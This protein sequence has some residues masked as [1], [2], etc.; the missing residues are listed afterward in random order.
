MNRIATSIRNR[1][2]L[3]PPQEKSL[4]I[5]AELADK[6][7]L[8]KSVDLTAELEKVKS[9]YPTC[10]DF[11]RNFPSLCFALATGVGKTRL[12]GAFIAY[13]YLAKGIKNFFVLA[14]N[15]TIYSKLKTE[16]EETSHPK[17]VF[18]GIGEFVHQRPGIITG[19]NYEN[20]RQRGLF[21][22][23][24]HINI[25][26]ISKI[27]AETRGGSSPR[28]KRLAECLGDSYFS[29]LINLEDLV[30][31]MDESHHYRADRGMQVI[32]ELNP[33]LGLELTATPQVEK[34]AKPVKFKNVVYE[35]SLAKAMKDGFVKEPAVATRK[36]F[37]PD[38][39]KK[40]PED[41][42]RIKL[43]DGIRLHEDTKVALDIYARDNKVQTVK[44]F[45]LV[46]AKETNHAG[47]L[48]ELIV[49]KSFF[50]GY[51]ADKVME[52]HSNQQGGEKDENI[53]Q[54]LSLESS[55]N[56]I[57]IVIHVN[58]LKEGWDVANLYTIIPLRS[59][60]SQTLREQT[61]GRGLRLPY[62]K[63]TGSDKVDKLTI[64]AHDRFQEILDEANMPDSIIRLENIIQIDP[65]ELN[66]QKEVVTS[67]SSIEQKMQEEQKRI[68]SIAQPEEKEKAQ[69]GLEVKRAVFSTLPELNREVKSIN[70]L[71]KSEIKEIAIEKI[72]QAISKSP[73]QSLFAGQMIKEVEKVYD[74]LVDEFTRNIIEIPRITVQQSGE[75]RSGFNNFE[76]DVKN[77]NFQPVSEEI[78]VKKLREQENSTDIV[79]GK[80]RIVPDSLD[81]IIVN[82]IINYSEIDYDVQA[83]LIFKLAGQVIEKFKTYLNEEQ[84]MNVVQYHKNEIGQYVYAQMMEHFYC[85]AP[86]FLKPIVRPFT[87]IE[88]PNFS[89]YTKDSIHHYRETITPTNKIPSKVFSGF[90]KACHTLYKFDS[91]TEK[92][93]ACILEQDK[94]VLKW[95]RPAA[96]QF[97]IYWKHNSRQ[98]HPDFVA[99]TADAI[100][101]IETKKDGDIDSAE[102]QE[103]SQ[104]ALT[105]CVHATEFTSQNGGKPWKYILIPHDVVKLNMGFDTLTKHYEYKNKGSKLAAQV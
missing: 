89:K 44:P 73:Q 47:K 10:A 76:L 58:M 91:K 38:Q 69:I 70:E 93:F 67:V 35:Y 72:R 102:V 52:I 32:N 15:L 85:E 22:S 104:A 87:R 54:L 53:A 79:I 8:K 42:D 81:K 90:K 60:A 4:N 25:F 17:Y 99:E 7:T 5:L 26:N 24:I 71:T 57:E 39:Y 95:L 1:L 94:A 82:E 9:S 37:D 16:F 6:L 84:I 45:V 36:D 80:G 68:E 40:A 2:S 41:L 103:K 46:V 78:L 97:H 88:E 56:K 20:F 55:D 86:S 29:Y 19:D 75:V 34:G 83:D 3:R 77:L 105:Y 64:V 96:N 98:Y 18:Q 74:K 21:E 48:K 14:P 61:I 33:I 43:E 12:M 28:I 59:A 51:Y 31:L 63:R 66:Q 11:E 62:G 101:M 13:L 92:D 100:Y 30:V 65:E 23:E 27:N 49:S 50:E